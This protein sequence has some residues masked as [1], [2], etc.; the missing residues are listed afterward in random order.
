L[1]YK[2]LNFDRQEKRILKSLLK[3]EMTNQTRKNVKILINNFYFFF[4]KFFFRLSLIIQL[5]I[6]GSG[7]RK[8][9]RAEPSYYYNILHNYPKDCHS[10]FQ[11][12]IEAVI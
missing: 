1:N 10:P 4:F 2:K 3:S 9:M 12:Q 5:W 8:Q 6:I 11:F 7:A